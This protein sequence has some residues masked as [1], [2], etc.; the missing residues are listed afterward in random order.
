MGH[1]DLL[2]LDHDVFGQRP[3]QLFGAF[4]GQRI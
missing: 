4:R 1:D 3:P 2:E